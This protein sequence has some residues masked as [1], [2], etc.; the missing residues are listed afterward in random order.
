MDLYNQ[1]YMKQVTCF[2]KFLD[3]MIMQKHHILQ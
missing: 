1:H 3:F 2:G